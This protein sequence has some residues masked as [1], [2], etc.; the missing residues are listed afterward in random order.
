MGAIKPLK[1]YDKGVVSTLYICFR[2]KEG[3]NPSFLEQY[4]ES[5]MLNSEIEKIA[6]EGARNHGLL[7]VG[8]ND[9]FNTRLLLPKNIEEQQKISL[10]LSTIDKL[11]NIQSEKIDL[12]EKH[13]KGLMQDLFPKIEN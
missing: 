12:L 13:K 10:C 8:I 11:I 4:F 1:K 9:F 6:Q 3:F 7:N 5:G 2:P